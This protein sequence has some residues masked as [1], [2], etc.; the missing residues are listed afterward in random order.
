MFSS[1][2]RVT[3]VAFIT[4]SWLSIPHDAHFHSF[5]SAADPVD[6]F[7]FMLWATRTI[8]IPSATN[9]K[10]FLAYNFITCSSA[11]P[12]KIFARS[13]HKLR[14]KNRHS[15][16][17]LHLFSL[18]TEMNIDHYCG[19]SWR[20][21][22]LGQ[23]KMG[24]MHRWSIPTGSAAGNP[25]FIPSVRAQILQ[26]EFFLISLVMP[27]KRDI[28]LT[29]LQYWSNIRSCRTTCSKIANFTQPFIRA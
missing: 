28:F 11:F 22:E 23:E 15:L 27:K 18:K 17:F 14:H 16:N 10:N 7:K 4:K 26:S 8:S 20:K 29:N 9:R 2:L 19:C 1:R 24:R 25:I 3:I 21:G 6:H 5:Q 13:A 12:L